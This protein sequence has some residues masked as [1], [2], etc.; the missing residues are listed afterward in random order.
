MRLLQRRADLPRDHALTRSLTLLCA[1]ALLAG[2]A[3]NATMV[4]DTGKQAQPQLTWLAHAEAL[5]AAAAADK[6]VLVHF[7]ADWCRWCT[8]MKQETYTD[9][10]VAALMREDFI[11]AMVDADREPQLKARYGVQGLP[12]IWFLTADG[13]GITYVPGFVDAPTFGKILRWIA[14]GAYRTEPFDQFTAS[15]G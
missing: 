1:V 11:T 7:T 8:K 14:T 9:P 10:A 12:T 13:Q 15:E 4:A 6:P 2:A 3:A 5:E